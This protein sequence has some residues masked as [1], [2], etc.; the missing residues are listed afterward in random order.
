MSYM[1]D[2]I[3]LE[4][5]VIRKCMENNEAEI[6]RLV[7]RLE[8]FKPHTVIMCG[9][10]TSDF[11]GQ[12]A[13]YLIEIFKGVPVSL[14]SPSVVT[15]YGGKYDM[16]GCLLIAV[17]QSGMGEDILAVTNRA[18]KCGAVTCSITNDAASPVALASEFRLDCSAGPELALAATKTFA[19]EIF[20]LY[21]FAARWSSSSALLS[22]LPHIPEYIED[23]LRCSADVTKLAAKSVD[24]SEVFVLAR[25]INFPMA[26]E[27]A[28][29]LSET[30]YVSAIPYPISDF[31][32]GPIAAVNENTP[33]LII[34]A[35]KETAADTGII[36]DK[37]SDSGARTI[38]I[39]S[40]PAE[41]G[42]FDDAIVLPE[43]CSGPASA[44]CI[45]PVIQMLA[46]RIAEARGLDSDH[47]RRLKKITITK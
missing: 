35:D 25:G 37:L 34:S 16:S 10:G 27:T 11:A 42:R 43:Q 13:K 31:Q 12:Y 30:S 32:H 3:N 19:A 21:L 44:F 6:C 39:T 18:A 22:Q 46:F 20:L 7:E 38:G 8:S 47:P 36:L 9:R 29:K 45:M 26:R 40:D 14:A 17:S 28:L 4:P 24:I 5:E 23:A 33:V 15:E 1:W 2:E 41:A